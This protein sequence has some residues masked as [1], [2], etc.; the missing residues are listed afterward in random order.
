MT[1]TRMKTIDCNLLRN[2]AL[3]RVKTKCWSNRRQLVLPDKAIQ[4][5]ATEASGEDDTAQ[6]DDGADRINEIRKRVKSSKLLVVVSEYESLVS[7]IHSARSTILRRFAVPS[8][9][10][11]GLYAVRL[12]SI[13]ALEKAISEMQSQISNVYLPL[14]ESVYAKAVEVAREIWN[15]SFRPADYPGVSVD[16]EGKLVVDA[17]ALRPLFGISFTYWAIS[18]PDGLPPE[19]REREERKLRAAYLEAEQRIID[20]L[21]TSFRKLVAHLADRLSSG[22]SEDVR[23]RRFHYTILDSLAEFVQSFKS[24]NVLDDARLSQL[25]AEAGQVLAS[26]GGEQATSLEKASLLRDS[27]SLRAAV[28]DDFRRI[29]GAVDRCIAELPGRSFEFED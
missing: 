22:D 14:L 3:V 25:V 2:C 24:R 28:A 10:E 27:A 15:G 26:I 12:E 16:S 17:S 18:V 29:Q 11:D 5:V 9:L 20:T 4:A 7:Y 23:K 21:Y 8:F 6:A 19:L 1:I 13:P